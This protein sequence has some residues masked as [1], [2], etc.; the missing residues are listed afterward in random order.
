MFVV[1]S[2][3]QACSKI[4][5]LI[6]ITPPFCLLLW[7][8][9]RTPFLPLGLPPT[10]GC[11]ACV[12]C[13]SLSKAEVTDIHLNIHTDGGLSR[14]NCSSAT[15]WLM[16]VVQ[17]GDLCGSL[18]HCLWREEVGVSSILKFLLKVE[19]HGVILSVLS[20][21]PRL[22][23]V[24]LIFIKGLGLMSSKHLESI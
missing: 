13:S 1:S 18:S 14:S 9:S 11:A 17:S 19:A 3:S 2:C 24:T 20:Y 10:W 23:T 21:S 15:H 4:Q 22:H 8:P 7:P 12:S 6:G 5:V 16:A